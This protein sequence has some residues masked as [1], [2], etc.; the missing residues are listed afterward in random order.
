MT[1]NNTLF[2]T[3][4]HQVYKDNRIF[5]KM[6]LDYNLINFSL[7]V[8]D[9]NK[10]TLLHLI[11]K[12]NDNDLFLS[13]LNHLKNANYSKEYKK[14]LIDATNDELNSPIH[15]AVINNNQ[16]MAE[17]LYRLDAI[18]DRPNRYG[19]AVKYSE[20]ETDNMS[21]HSEN[22]DKKPNHSENRLESV[23]SSDVFRN[24]IKNIIGNN[25]ENN[26]TDT[27]STIDSYRFNNFVESKVDNINKIDFK[28]D[29]YKLD[30]FI[31][32]IN[33]RQHG[34]GNTELETLSF[35]KSNINQ[36]TENNT[37]NIDNNYS[38]STSTYNNSSYNSSN[39]SSNNSSNNSE[40]NNSEY[41][42]S[43]NNSSSNS[44]SNNSSNNSEYNN[45]SN[46]SDTLDLYKQI[47]K[48]RK[49]SDYD[50]DSEYELEGG[51]KLSRKLK[52]QTENFHEQVLDKLKSNPK[53][54]DDA[55]FIKAALWNYIKDKYPNDTNYDKSKKMFELSESNQF[56]KVLSS[57]DIQAIKAI[58]SSK[59]A[60]K[61][62]NK[63]D[64]K[65]K[66]V[67]K[68]KSDKKEKSVKKEKKTDKKEKTEKK[69]KSKK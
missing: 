43:S 39:D 62:D 28:K 17:K 59:I 25:S 27:A 7:C 66:S 9:K 49:E 20:T 30:I 54:R 6:I 4:L 3:K 14:N 50:S 57:L 10:N 63:T 12:D 21:Q 19:F 2:E 24:I 40:S 15:L 48:I 11:V 61:E 56:D 45:S 37:I 44:E 35:N 23:N 55:L 34:G 13:Y 5:I 64:K 69:S 52:R 67:K 38:N 1:F 32:N 26:K 58:V 16:M 46:D 8:C 18:T 68:E 53:Y 47:K 51:K 42:N 29:D 22:C 65:E 41:N 36:Y 33:D 31:D 60:S